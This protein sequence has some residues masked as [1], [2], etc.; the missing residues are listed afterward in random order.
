VPALQLVF[1]NVTNVHQT[2]PL[3]TTGCAFVAGASAAKLSAQS[4]STACHVVAYPLILGDLVVTMAERGSEVD[5]SGG[6]RGVIKPCCC[7]QAAFP[8][9][10]TWC[11][12]V[13]DGR[14]LNQ[15]RG[16]VEIPVPRLDMSA[17]L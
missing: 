5:Q 14:E 12:R 15:D 11:A 4:D 6:H 7:S 17:V 8:E 9:R 10:N 16:P 3:V 1:E 13:A 2:G